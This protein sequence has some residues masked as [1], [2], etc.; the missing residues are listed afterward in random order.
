MK[1]PNRKIFNDLLKA[2]ELDKQ[3]FQVINRKSDEEAWFKFLD[4]DLV[5][6]LR[7]SQD[8]VV[9]ETESLFNTPPRHPAINRIQKQLRSR[10]FYTKINSEA[11]LVFVLE[12]VSDDKGNVDANNKSLGPYFWE[13][14]VEDL[15]PIIDITR[16]IVI[17]KFPYL[18][19]QQ[20]VRIGE[21]TILVSEGDLKG[22]TIFDAFSTV[23][24]KPI[25]NKFYWLFNE[26]FL[27]SI[28]ATDDMRLLPNFFLDDDNLYFFY[29]ERVVKE[30]R[31]N[32]T[33]YETIGLKKKS[34]EGL[35]DFLRILLK[36]IE[37]LP[38]QE[39]HCYGYIPFNINRLLHDKILVGTGAGQN[40]LYALN[41]DIKDFK[42]SM[43]ARKETCVYDETE[44]AEMAQWYEMLEDAI[45]EG[46]HLERVT[47]S[48]LAARA[49][50]EI[51]RTLGAEK[52][53]ISR[54]G[55][56]YGIYISS[57]ESQICKFDKEVSVELIEEGDEKYLILRSI[58]S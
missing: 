34:T 52:R 46:K 49:V 48:R 27:G 6:R 38:E 26:W 17:T 24:T 3:R 15:S 13:L 43:D 23:I 36:K 5:A 35:F 9:I 28:H 57:T 32:I 41:S 55:G 58:S 22:K 33:E 47:K 53:K 14:L 16:Q 39:R 25:D 18:A 45:V 10:E 56:G 50:S 54:S 31:A 19:R 44:V 1:Y 8:V 40:I 20:A 2:I 12:F 4:Y 7:V 30:K 37:S 21:E 51:P 42:H 11:G 29:P